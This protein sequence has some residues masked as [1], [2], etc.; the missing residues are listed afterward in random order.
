M[1]FAVSR[2]GIATQFLRH[3]LV[4]PSVVYFFVF[5]TRLLVVSILGGFV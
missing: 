4:L 1:V 5:L 3:A 2:F